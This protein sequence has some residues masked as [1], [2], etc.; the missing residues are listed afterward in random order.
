[1]SSPIDLSSLLTYIKSVDVTPE[2]STIGSPIQS[3]V[4]PNVPIV[5]IFLQRLID[6]KKVDPDALLYQ[7]IKQAEQKEDLL[8]LALALRNGANPNSYVEI[9]S[10]GTGHI[11]IYVHEKFKEHELDPR[12]HPLL[13]SIVI[14]LVA[15]G[16]KTVLPAF[17]I[18]GGTVRRGYDD[19]YQAESVQEWFS[20]C[21][22]PTVLPLLQ[23]EGENLREE[24]DIL[25]KGEVE[26]RNGN[27]YVK[28]DGRFRE[29]LSAL[30]DRQEIVS[31]SPTECM[32]CFEHALKWNS[33]ITLGDCF[34]RK[35]IQRRY[36]GL[37]LAIENISIPAVKR[38]LE[39]GR[40]PNYV[41]VNAALL[42]M[43]NV[44]AFEKQV[45]LGEGTLTIA[46]T[47]RPSIE[48]L[49]MLISAGGQID[50]YQY[51]ML[52]RLVPIDAPRI[53]KQYSEPY[54]SKVCSVN[55]A[56]TTQP[57]LPFASLEE[58]SSSTAVNSNISSDVPLDLMQLAY[59]LNL[60]PFSSRHDICDSLGKLVKAN[61]T[62]LKAAAIKRQMLR[63][64]SSVA[65][66][67][68]FMSNISNKSSLLCRNRELLDSNPYEYNDLDLS[69][70]K[71]EIG[72]LWC[73]TSDMFEML[74]QSQTN[75]FT[76]QKLSDEYISA[77]KSQRNT[78]KRLGYPV[79]SS[80]GPATFS[81]GLANL[82][83][84]DTITNEKT[85]VISSTFRKAAAIHGVTAEDLT[86]ISRDVMI[87]TFMSVGLYEPQLTK[88][89]LEHA[90]AT[91][92]RISV[93]LLKNK[94]DCVNTFFHTL[95]KSLS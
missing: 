42:S 65:T 66:T 1:M 87:D 24:R 76:D 26:N 36:D 33:P 3:E 90:K 31:E 71:D 39:M 28:I 32:P 35:E 19:H 46:D 60:D 69:Y 92:Y 84:V 45:G 77:L 6:T 34:T 40:V 62:E 78:L 81:E 38:Y 61:P 47:I 12:D 2:S 59:T 89:E 16:A 37:R 29:Y 41:E 50:L 74:I 52:S 44:R 20:S 49:E 95:F 63:I 67:D 14:M 21:G 75:P 70:Y 73:F 58:R 94:P 91:F 27:T 48:I 8:P 30:L 88:L 10:I 4:K 83:R 11:L 17:D 51:Q 18:Q 85:D 72:V 55:E 43:Q 9:E 82:K 54:W 22:Y 25:T 80:S 53:Q 86:K 5:A 93:Q 13:S 15:S 57:L 56:K 64:S 7:S 68:D 79:S 23:A